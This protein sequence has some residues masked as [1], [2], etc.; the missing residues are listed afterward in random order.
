MQL[1]HLRVVLAA[2]DVDE[3]SITILH[4]AG[5]LAAAAN[6]RLHVIHSAPFGAG[7]GSQSPRAERER[8][9]RG[10][11]ERAG[12]HIDEI[13]VH[14]GVGEPARVIHSLADWIRADVIVL[15]RH[16]DRAE[17]NRPMGDTAL[18][19]VT[20]SWAPCLI[21]SGPM[22][23]PLERVLVPVD[24]SDNSRGALTVA[25]S[26]ASA[27]RGAVVPEGTTLTEAVNLTAIYVDQASDPGGSSPIH[28]LD[29][30]LG[31]LRRDAGTWAGV[32]INSAVVRSRDVAAAVAGYARD[33]EFDI[34]VLGTRGVGL[35]DVSRIGSIS[36]DVT[37]RI[38]LPILLVPPA[39]WTTRTSAA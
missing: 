14:L 1:L 11:V 2:I 27:L 7:N 6:A 19:I 34:V 36:R 24:L 13:T 23:L 25:L 26:W 16:R 10:L 33:H 30:T 31:R 17:A 39:M 5:E 3:Q 4:G 32:A 12:L 20:S 8:I 9:I 35:D 21:L 15:G 29:D 28:A 37:R 18:Q 22:R 38:A